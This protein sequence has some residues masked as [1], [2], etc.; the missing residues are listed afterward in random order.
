MIWLLPHPAP[1]LLLS[2]V[3]KPDRRHTGRLIYIYTDNLLT[4]EGEEGGAG[5]KSYDSKKAW[6][7]INHSILSGWRLLLELESFAGDLRRNTSLS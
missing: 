1:S 4:G 2:P 7:S 3:S 5:A 6:S